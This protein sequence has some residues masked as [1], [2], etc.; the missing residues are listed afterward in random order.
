MSSM[1]TVGG[2]VNT[3]VIKLP[4]LVARY[5]NR[6]VIIWYKSTPHRHESAFR[7]TEPLSSMFIN[8]LLLPINRAS[9]GGVLDIT[10]KKREILSSSPNTIDREKSNKMGRRLL[11]NPRLSTLRLKLTVSWLWQNCNVSR[12]QPIPCDT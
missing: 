12:I 3:C 1:G 2:S 4:K 5:G 6:P 7:S 11:S 8:G 9:S 10:L